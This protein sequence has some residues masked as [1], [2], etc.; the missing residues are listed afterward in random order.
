MKIL[1]AEWFSNP[2]GC[3]GIVT[4]KNDIGEIKSYLGLGDGRSEHEDIEYIAK[5]GAKVDVKQLKRIVNFM[6]GRDGTVRS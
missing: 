1:N 6:E 5:T 2:Q 3:F 4:I